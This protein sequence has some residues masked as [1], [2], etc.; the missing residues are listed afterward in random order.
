MVARW[1]KLP[2]LSTGRDELNSGKDHSVIFGVFKNLG[3]F[4]GGPEK[5]NDT[6]RY[7]GVIRSKLR[8]ETKIQLILCDW[9]NRGRIVNSIGYAVSSLREFNNRLRKIYIYV[10]MYV[11]IYIYMYLY[12]KT[13]Y[14]SYLPANTKR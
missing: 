1:E 11:C 6:S 14:K 3:F 7:T 10:C 5:V 13:L 9:S 2:T 8:R 4:P 12:I